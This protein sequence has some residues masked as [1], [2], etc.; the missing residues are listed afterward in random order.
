MT[1]RERIE[2]A[3]GPEGTPEV[4]SVICYERIFVRDHWAE[5]TQRPWW[6]M[7]SP[8]L[9]HQLSWRRGTIEQI[10]QDWFH[11]PLCRPRADRENIDVELR[12]RDVFEVDR[13]TGAS[14][15]VEP[16]EVGR[17]SG[18]TGASRHPKSPADTSDEIDE[19]LDIAALG[20]PGRIKRD[21]QGDLAERMLAE[22][23]DRI[24]PIRHVASPLWACYGLWGF[25]GLMIRIAERRDL[26]RHACRRCL[27]KAAREVRVASELGCAGIWIEECMTDMVDPADFAEF[28]TPYVAEL[29]DEIRAAGL[30]SI[31]YFAGDPEGKLEAVV[32]TRPD[33]VSLEEGKKGFAIEIEDI[34]DAIAGRCAVL[35][36]L[37]AVA[38]LQDGS[39]EVLRAEIRRQLQAGVRNGNR[40]LMSLGSPVTPSTPVRRVRLY[41]DMVREVAGDLSASP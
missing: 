10:G 3:L 23:G 22:C 18:T 32:S 5:L 17:F 16:F 21:G 27:E 9:D 30:R 2:A 28:S 6:H 29:I 26:V 40:F 35:G 38:V 25:E 14:T 24:F 41:C 8:D 37:D 11:L 19:Q 4:P 34:V 20:D 15:R 12:G 31:Y 1:G 33:A 39:E 13:R 7:H 36:N